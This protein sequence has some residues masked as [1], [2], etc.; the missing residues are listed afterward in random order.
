MSLHYFD[1]HH[2]VIFV[3]ITYGFIFFM[4]ARWMN[5]TIVNEESKPGPVG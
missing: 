5:K 3:I 4:V 1:L 2:S